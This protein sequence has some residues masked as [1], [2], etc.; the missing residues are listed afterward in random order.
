MSKA[1]ADN[2][3]DNYNNTI[4][5]TITINDT[6]LYD[7]VVTLSSQDNQKLSKFQ[8][9]LRVIMSSLTKKKRD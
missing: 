7:L 4:I 3:D 1:G 9:L 2:D 6:N 8:N 5:I